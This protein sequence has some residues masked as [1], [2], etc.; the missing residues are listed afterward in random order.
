MTWVLS[1]MG[2]QVQATCDL[3]ALLTHESSECWFALEPDSTI[4]ARQRA[5]QQLGGAQH[6]V[7]SYSGLL[8]CSNTDVQYS[9]YVSA[10]VLAALAST[11]LRVMAEPVPLE[12]PEMQHSPRESPYVEQGFMSVG[13]SQKAQG[14]LGFLVRC[15]RRLVVWPGHK[16]SVHLPLRSRRMAGQG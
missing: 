14:V 8:W 4:A 16:Y 13:A 6:I 2:W 7:V 5:P 9:H 10:A 3:V 1:D 11:V 12:P 15:D